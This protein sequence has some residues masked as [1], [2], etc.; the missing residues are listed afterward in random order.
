M[1]ELLRKSGKSFADLCVTFCLTSGCESTTTGT[2]RSPSRALTLFLLSARV[3]T[4]SR[5]A[6][7]KQ[8]LSQHGYGYEWPHVSE[9][10]AST[11]V[12]YGMVYDLRFGQITNPHNYIL[13]ILRDEAR[14]GP[15]PP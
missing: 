10:P 6:H 15:V 8:T 9:G 2:A 12:F 13:I 14:R 3:R 5:K 1:A 11:E 4:P 7:G